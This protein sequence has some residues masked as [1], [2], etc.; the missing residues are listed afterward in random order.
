M[1]LV[2]LIGVGKEHSGSLPPSQ[3]AYFYLPFS[4]NAHKINGKARHFEHKRTEITEDN[5]HDIMMHVI[6]NVTS[7][8]TPRLGTNN[9]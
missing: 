4:S 3:S 1:Y 6:G 5:I 2:Y 7:L 9:K 8:D